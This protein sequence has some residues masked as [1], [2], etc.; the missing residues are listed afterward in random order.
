MLLGEFGHT[1]DREF[2][3]ALPAR[4]RDALGDEVADGLCL[5]CGAEAC[6]VACPRSRLQAIVEDV[7]RDPTLS[8]RAVRDFKRALGS[9]SAVVSPDAQGRIRIPDAL[10]EHAGIDRSVT[11]VGAVDAIEI[12]DADSYGSREAGRNATYEKVASEIFA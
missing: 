3:L 11:V 2:R 4:L 9:R 6:I 8:R 7:V 10:R 1:L 12:W 5:L